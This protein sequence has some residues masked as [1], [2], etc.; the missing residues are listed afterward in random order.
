MHSVLADRLA[1]ELRQTSTQR[2][3]DEFRKQSTMIAS[4]ASKLRLAKMQRRQ[5]QSSEERETSR[6][7]RR[8]LWLAHDNQS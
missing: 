7:P 2:L 6:A 8:R 4:L 5:H 1:A 3:R